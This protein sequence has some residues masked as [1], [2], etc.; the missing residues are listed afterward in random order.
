MKT[1][2]K[3]EIHYSVMSRSHQKGEFLLRGCKPEQVPLDFWKQ[4]KRDMSYRASL[5]KIL[6]EDED[7]TQLV[8]DLE[9]AERKKK[10]D[11]ANDYLPF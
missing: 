11:I 6:C 1:T 4:I 8:I 5:E 7:I 3:I 9:I 10:D 2:V